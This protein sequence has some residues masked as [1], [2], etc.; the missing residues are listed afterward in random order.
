M[1]ITEAE[2]KAAYLDYYAQRAN[3][4]QGLDATHRIMS[5]DEFRSEFLA[6]SGLTFE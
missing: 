5:F 6:K 2:I 3:F 4:V 1:I